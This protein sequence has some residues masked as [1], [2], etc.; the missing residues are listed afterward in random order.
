MDGNYLAL[1]TIFMTLLIIT[2]Q[3]TAPARRRL[4]FAFAALCLLILR[5]YTLLKSDLHAETMIAFVLALLLAG[6]FWLLIG[7][8]NPV[9]GD[10]EIQ[11]MSMDD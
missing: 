1:I 6:V 5:H 2:I 11:V 10:D 8:Y 7:R 3:R 4:L 9:K